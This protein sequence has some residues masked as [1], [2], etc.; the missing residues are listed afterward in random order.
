[1]LHVEQVVLEKVPAWCS[2][3]I[4]EVNQV[5]GVIEEEAGG[6]LPTASAAAAPV[7]SSVGAW[8]RR[9]KG[10][11]G[12]LPRGLAVKGPTS[13]S[14]EQKGGGEIMAMLEKI[15]SGLTW[16]ER[17]AATS[18]AVQTAGS[19]NPKEG[20]AAGCGLLR[21]GAPEHRHRDVTAWH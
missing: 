12:L 18:N 6:L 1:M 3:A 20:A 5:Q 15:R 21:R 9:A 2:K 13:L 7:P 17:V 8:V 11:E 19:Q 14:W 4:K 16:K 10:T